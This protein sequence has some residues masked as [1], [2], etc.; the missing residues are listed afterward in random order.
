MTNLQKWLGKYNNNI[1]T[2]NCKLAL[3]LIVH[4]LYRT[5]KGRI[6]ISKAILCML[7]IKKHKKIFK[8]KFFAS[9]LKKGL[10]FLYEFMEEKKP[11]C[12]YNKFLHTFEKVGCLFSLF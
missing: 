10:F 9:L 5:I 2:K 6:Q 4:M 12:C 7:I 3:L 11:T 8:T 1:L